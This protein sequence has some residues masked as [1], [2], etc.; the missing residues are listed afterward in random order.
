MIVRGGPGPLGPCVLLQVGG[1][2]LG[3]H[4]LAAGGPGPDAPARVKLDAIH[5]E[6]VAGQQ[7]DVGGA[8]VRTPAR[9]RRQLG[10]VPA[11]VAGDAHRRLLHEEPCSGGR[12][13]G[14]DK[15][16]AELQAVR[17]DPLQHPSPNAYAP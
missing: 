11:A 17:H 14:R 5:E 9:R 13:A 8:A 1:R 10:L 12:R 6:L 2:D 15:L 3:R 7:L 4:R 16:V